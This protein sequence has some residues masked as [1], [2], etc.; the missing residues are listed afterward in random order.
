MIYCTLLTPLAYSGKGLGVENLC[1]ETWILSL[2]SIDYNFRQRQK[3][4]NVRNRVL[5]IVSI[6]LDC[7]CRI[8]LC[9]A[10]SL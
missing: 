7:V 6:S 1:D 5:T 4:V 9:H 8:S 2:I 3:L 10:A